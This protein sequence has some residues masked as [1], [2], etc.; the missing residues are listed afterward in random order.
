VMRISRGREARQ[1][2][3]CVQRPGESEEPEWLECV[4]GGSLSSPQYSFP[5]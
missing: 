1:R 4:R 3:Q 5:M 2:E